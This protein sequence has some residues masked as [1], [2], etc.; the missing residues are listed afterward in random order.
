MLKI[1]LKA[2]EICKVT[3]LWFPK[4]QKCMIILPGCSDMRNRNN[5]LYFASSLKKYQCN[6]LCT[7]LLLLFY[8]NASSSSGII[9]EICDNFGPSFFSF[10]RVVV[11]I[12]ENTVF[13]VMYTVPDISDLSADG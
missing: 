13:I 1:L 2:N 7:A 4:Y 6:I 12:R 8:R 9:C 10:N 11:E 5:N 3:P